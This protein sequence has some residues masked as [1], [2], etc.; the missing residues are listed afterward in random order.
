[1][2]LSACIAFGVT[3][4]VACS[5][6]DGSTFTNGN[7]DAD[8]EPPPPPFTDGGLDGSGETGA[9]QCDPAIPAAFSPSWAAPAKKPSPAACTAQEMTDYYAACLNNPDTKAACS[10]FTAA[11]ATCAA[12]VEPTNLAGPVQWHTVAGEARKYF[13]INIAGCLALEQ[14]KLGENDCGGAY[15]AAVQC[16]RSSCETCLATGGL[17]SQF[18]SCQKSVQQEGVCNSYENVQAAACPNIKNAGQP[19]AD[20]FPKV[21]EQVDAYSARVMAIYCGP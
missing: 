11:H 7:P 1:M 16:E 2:G 4:I 8:A 3:M 20:C 6:S 15:N 10:T 9:P 18:S 14:D 19:T 12:C 21:G 17:F 5:G 13:T